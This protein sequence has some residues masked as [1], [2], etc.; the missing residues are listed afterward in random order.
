MVLDGVF[1]YLRGVV[2]YL[3]DLI[4]PDITLHDEFVFAFVVAHMQTK[5][6]SPTEGLQVVDDLGLS[7]AILEIYVHPGL[8]VVR[9]V[10]KD[11]VHAL[12][13]LA[14]QVSIE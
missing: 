14:G 5:I 10:I 6:I 12:V 11:P 8:L 3:L 2:E 4:E 7:S 1:A 9:E 13:Y